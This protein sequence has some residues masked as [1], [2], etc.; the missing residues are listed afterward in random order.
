MRNIPA[1]AVVVTLT[2]SLKA[3]AA[4]NFPRRCDIPGTTY[5]WVSD[6]CMLKHQ[7]DDYESEAVSG[8]CIP[9]QMKIRFATACERKLH[10]KEK[11]CRLV[12]K[13]GAR[14]RTL[15]SCM[16]DPGFKGYFVG[17]N[18]IGQERK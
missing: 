11:M 13:S 8:Q 15:A 9:A 7:T 12:I 3:S 4:A 6:Y 16:D 2:V 18:R 5:A 14:Y 1:I 17:G 10:Y